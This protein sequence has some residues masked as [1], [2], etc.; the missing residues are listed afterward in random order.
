MK[1]IFIIWHYICNYKKIK[2]Y[3]AACECLNNIKL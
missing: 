2:E 1:I 3:K